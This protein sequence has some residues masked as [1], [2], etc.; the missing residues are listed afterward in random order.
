MRLSLCL[1]GQLCNV[2]S[3]FSLVTLLTNHNRVRAYPRAEQRGK[4][5]CLSSQFGEIGQ[6]GPPEKA[7]FFITVTFTPS[8]LLVK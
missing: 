3:S 8:C 5:I 1:T 6:Q 4:Q 2:N 7:P